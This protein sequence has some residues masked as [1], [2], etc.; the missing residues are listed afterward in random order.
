MESIAEVLER[1]LDRLEF[2]DT[3]A[4]RARDFR[5]QELRLQRFKWQTMR[6]SCGRLTGEDP[7]LFFRR[8]ERHLESEYW[9]ELHSRVIVERGPGCEGC[10]GPGWQLHHRTYK[11][12]GQELLSDVT[13]YCGPCHA[14]RHA[15]L[16]VALG[17][18]RDPEPV[19][20][21]AV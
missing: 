18:P 1:V 17:L 6:T 16:R 8:Y 10:G 20:G 13:L 4:L 5:L 7:D 3:P 14:A 12:L 11:R 9:R 19:Y 2:G 15:D 21:H